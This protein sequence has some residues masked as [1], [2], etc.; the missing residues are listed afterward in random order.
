MLRISETQLAGLEAGVRD[1]LVRRATAR[2]AAQTGRSAAEL[3]P[4]AVEMQ[5]FAEARSLLAEESL[6]A[7]MELRLSPWW[8]DPLPALSVMFL[9]RD[10]FPEE[11]RVQQFRQALA[12]PSV[13]LIDLDDAIPPRSR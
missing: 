1:R 5:A 4:I 9:T 10:G 11:A 8:R 3:H 6:H 7:L 13:T 2:A 12:A